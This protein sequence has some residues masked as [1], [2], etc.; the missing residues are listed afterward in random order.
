MRS[1]RRLWA[2]ML[3][4]TIITAVLG[5]RVIL[6][7]LSQRDEAQ[8]SAQV[9]AGV[10][11]SLA[12][13][14]LDACKSGSEKAQAL[15]E[16]GLCKQADATKDT[17]DE[18]RVEPSEATPAPT[19]Y[20]PPDPNQLA[21]LVRSDVYRYCGSDGSC[22]G[23]DGKDGKPATIA[24]VI[25]A[26]GQMIDEALVRVCGGSCVGPKGDSVTGPQGEPG[27]GLTGE[28]HCDA[29]GRFVFELTNG[30]ESVVQGSRCRER[31]VLKP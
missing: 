20:L 16:Q 21:A 29:Q 9:T 25:S 30:E 5:T 27:V 18:A 8:Q 23:E 14:V 22:E 4:L 31:G 15:R 6:D 10:G 7:S 1:N 11:E 24:Q 12:D 26:V 3:V 17:I 2:A 13:Q 28:S 19:K